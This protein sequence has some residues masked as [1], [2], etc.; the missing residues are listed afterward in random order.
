L[1]GWSGDIQEH[2]TD[3]ERLLCRDARLQHL[4]PAEPDARNDIRWAPRQL[5]DF[6]DVVAGIPHRLD[7]AHL[8]LVRAVFALGH[9]GCIDFGIE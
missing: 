1:A 6:G 5:L 8:D 3:L 4:L 2:V 7:A 9:S